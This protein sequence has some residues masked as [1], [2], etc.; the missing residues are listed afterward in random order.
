MGDLT[1]SRGQKLALVRGLAPVG[2]EGAQKGPAKGQINKW[3]RFGEVELPR[4]PRRVPFRQIGSVNVRSQ[5]WGWR[6]I[7]W[8]LAGTP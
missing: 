5:R 2:M 6:T 7:P 8:D 4:P 3:V 1:P